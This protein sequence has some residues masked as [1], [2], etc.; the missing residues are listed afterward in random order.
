VIELTEEAAILSMGNARLRISFG[1]DVRVDGTS[2]TLVGPGEGTT[3]GGEA[4]E[5]A[6]RS[7]RS[8]TASHDAVPAYVIL[9][10]AELSDI[11]ARDPSSLAQLAKCR[12]IGQIRL[13][14]W[15]DE[16]LAVLEAAR[17]E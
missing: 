6:L 2:V 16:I 7:W 11:A 5:K 8:E 17:S 1:S 14:R 10:D 9:K 12:G 4:A 3:T 15:G 13:E